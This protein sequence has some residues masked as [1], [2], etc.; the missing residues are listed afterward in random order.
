MTKAITP[1]ITPPVSKVTSGEL[2]RRL[3]KA[4]LPQ[5][6]KKLIIAMCAMLVVSV[7]M[8]LSAY[9]IQ[10]L[11]DSGLINRRI[12]VL[13]TVIIALICLTIVKGIAYYYQ[14]YYMEWV[15]Q[16]VIADLQKDLFA[17]I[18]SQDLRFY[19]TNP[20][21]TLTARFTSDLQRLKIALTQVFHAGVRD[22]AIIIGLLANMLYQD[23]Q[24]TLLALVVLPLSFFPIRQFGRLMRK[25][26]HLNQESIGRLSHKLNE[27][28]NHIRQVQAFTME[29]HECHRANAHINDVF[30]TTLRAVRIRA[31]SS[32]TVEL[33]G[34]IAI[35]IIMLYAGYRIA[36][37]V[38]TPGAFASFM[39]S[40]VIIIR[41]IKGL[42]NLNNILQDGLSAAH[43]TFAIM[44]EPRRVHDLSKAKKLKVTQGE[45]QFEDVT[46]TYSDGKTA[47]ESLTLTVP[48]G[49]TVALV[50]SS[51]AG[52]STL[53]NLIP[54]F[55]DPTEGQILIDG[56]AIKH[57]TLFSLRQHI[58]LVTQDVA[59]F[60]DS[61]AANIAYGNPSATEKEIVQAAKDAAA[62]DF[63]DQL[64]DG[65]QTNLGENG[66]KLSGGQKQ[67]IA[68]ARAL[69]SKSPIL[70]L[71]EATSSLDTVSE[72]KVQKA[73]E[74]LMKNRTTLVI[75]HRL[76]TIVSADEI[77]VLDN[78]Q[79]VEQGT[80]D[81][82]L[83]KSGKY[84]DLWRMQQK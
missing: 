34:T 39:A 6:K 79:I 57:T 11:F 3:A 77:V 84:S 12:G 51:G 27:S 47:L 70:L 58:A 68:I 16:R 55:F 63:I 64:P 80:H 15:G 48:A 41:P 31:I 69:V 61:A 24:L 25:Y 36:D 8:S 19:Q 1:P 21:A 38:L 74:K 5:H 53:L 33:I 76:S 43:R 28:F 10:P 82:L 44:D 71:D 37:G 4:Y 62:H 54:R 81:K 73:L 78:G 18:M 22:M 26:A 20:T 46:L 7:T 65:Y 42:T 29:D 67:R 13:N 40:A 14:G 32:P 9:Y 75:A 45:I 23:W 60:D 59:I 30:D 83:K 56:Q 72:R 49:K 66:V 52:K 2:L 17:R 50:G 35:G